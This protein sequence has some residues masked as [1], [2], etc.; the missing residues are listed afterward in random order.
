MTT[1]DPILYILAANFI[2]ATFGFFCASILA[3]RKIQ[4]LEKDTWAA[5]NT[6]YTRQA[7]ATRDPFDRYPGDRGSEIGHRR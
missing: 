1:P 4:R 6:Y 3:S 2:G 7:A 5:A